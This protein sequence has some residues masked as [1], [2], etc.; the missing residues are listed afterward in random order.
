MPILLGLFAGRAW[1]YVLGAIVGVA[2][3]AWFHHDIVAP[4]QAQIANLK[5]QLV[6]Q[7]NAIKQSETIRE[8][9]AHQA[10][11]DRQSAAQANA[12]LMEIIHVSSI[13]PGACRL[14]AA[15]LRRLR[16]IAGYANPNASEYGTALPEAASGLTE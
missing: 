14:D 10:D 1:I 2:L 12:Q 8:A 15:A 13:D 3:L 7:A 9:D 5:A 11:I 6:A 16:V 4:Y